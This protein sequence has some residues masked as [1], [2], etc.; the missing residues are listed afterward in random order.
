[1]GGSTDR[2]RRVF[3]LARKIREK[4]RSLPV[5][6]GAKVENTEEMLRGDRQR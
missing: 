4:Q 2:R 3:D 1:M 6:K 5:R